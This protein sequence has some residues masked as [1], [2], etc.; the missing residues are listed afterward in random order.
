MRL[1]CPVIVAFLLSSN[2]FFATGAQSQDVNRKANV[3]FFAESN[4]AYDSVDNLFSLR[5]FVDG[6]YLMSVA[7]GGESRAEKILVKGKHIIRVYHGPIATGNKHEIN[8]LSD[9]E[10][11]I[12]IVWAKDRSAHRTTVEAVEL[13]GKVLDYKLDEVITERT[14]RR[15]QPFV[16]EKGVTKN[17]EDSIETTRTVT[18]SNAKKLG[19]NSGVKIAA[20][21]LGIKNELEETVTVSEAR[22]QRRTRSATIN[23]DGITKYSTV[24]VKHLKKGKATVQIDG[25]EIKDVEFEILVDFDLKVEKVN[26]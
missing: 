20:L 3:S 25:T 26:E 16:V 7:P 2:L 19:D 10:F 4:R 13:G 5:I 11:N 24:W 17:I 1:S 9:G 8:V 12:K 23:G 6:E 21:E 15:S 22:T 18:V 14:V